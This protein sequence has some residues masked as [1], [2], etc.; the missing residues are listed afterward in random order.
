MDLMTLGLSVVK[1]NFQLG[2]GIRV[3]YVD[4]SK[5]SL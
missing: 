3:E 1:H 2:D 5:C 4:P